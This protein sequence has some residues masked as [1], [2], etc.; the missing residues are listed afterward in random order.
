MYVE[1]LKSEPVTKTPSIEIKINWVIQIMA[2]S[3]S[4]ID[5]M[6]MLQLPIQP[7]V[8]IL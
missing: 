1:K 2:L 5:K 4:I 6:V 8:L 3:N 7:Q